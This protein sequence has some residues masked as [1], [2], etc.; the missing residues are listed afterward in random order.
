M[1]LPKPTTSA[2][3]QVPPTNVSQRDLPPSS[4]IPANT[5]TPVQELQDDDY[6]QT[7]NAQSTAQ[8]NKRSLQTRAS[9]PGAYKLRS[10]TANPNKKQPVWK[11]DL[12]DIS[13]SAPDRQEATPKQHTQRSTDIETPNR[14]KVNQFNN[15]P[16]TTAQSTCPQTKLPVPQPNAP[17]SSEAN[18]HI[19]YTHNIMDHDRSFLMAKLTPTYRL[20]TT[21]KPTNKSTPSYPEMT[22]TNMSITVNQLPSPNLIPFHTIRPHNEKIVEIL[23]QNSF[24]P[25]GHRWTQQVQCSTNNKLAKHIK[26]PTKSQVPEL[27]I[28]VPQIRLLKPPPSNNDLFPP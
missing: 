25:A 24:Q 21:S 9:H 10:K 2:Q 28:Q 16:T 19:T 20:Q 22:H 27:T 23:H 1:S 15:H 11:Q 8:N 17:N 6:Q 5:N 4:T 12:I 7:S 14:H 3:L 13:R 18:H 26:E